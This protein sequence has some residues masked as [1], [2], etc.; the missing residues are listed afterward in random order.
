MHVSMLTVI[1]CRCALQSFFAQCRPL[2]CVAINYR[3]AV[4]V[5]MGG[6]S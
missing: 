3:P 5:I 2:E 1:A 6:A 4:F